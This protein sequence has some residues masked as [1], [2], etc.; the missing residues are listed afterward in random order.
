MYSD[1]EGVAGRKVKEAAEAVAQ[2]DPV[3]AA[4]IEVKKNIRK[5]GRKAKEKAQETVSLAKEA[6][7]RK[8]I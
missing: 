4:E 8:G 7:L 6:N 2:S 3:A 5:T 1:I